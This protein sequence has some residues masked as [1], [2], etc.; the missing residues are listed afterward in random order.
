M[1]MNEYAR[2]CAR[3][4]AGGQLTDFQGSC[5][6][7][8]WIFPHPYA[9]PRGHPRLNKHNVFLYTENIE[10]EYTEIPTSQG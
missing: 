3:E 2:V 8:K 7:D 5:H 1:R 9:V 4:D 10:N 6:S